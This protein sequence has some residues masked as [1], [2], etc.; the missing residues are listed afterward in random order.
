MNPGFDR[1]PR[2]FLDIDRT[3]LAGVAVL[4]VAWIATLA[5]SAPLE[6]LAAALVPAGLWAALLVWLA[7]REGLPAARIAL[8]FLWGAVIAV[9]AASALDQGAPGMLSPWTSATDE[10]RVLLVGPIVEELAKAVVIPLLLV[11]HP[12]GAGGLVAAGALYGALSGLGFATS[13]NVS[14]FL[15]ATLHGG[16]SGLAVAVWSRGVV[17][18]CKHSVY[19]ATTGLGIGWALSCREQRARGI[20]AAAT[21][22]V[23]AVLQHSAWNGLVAP[24]MHDALCRS[25]GATIGC[26]PT[27][28]AFD[29]LVLA[30]A[31]A[32]L[33]LAP[34][35]VGLVV[36][37]RRAQG[38]LRSA[39][40]DSA[41]GPRQ[42]DASRV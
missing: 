14:Y 11:A 38:R 26:K 33:A 4:A 5:D 2:R 29:L 12:R 1:S 34:A 7:R 23:A 15:M 21:A 25:D 42:D 36:L 17:A 13:E 30:P 37:R 27:S 40:R 32:V 19:A 39:Y 6:I 31:W 10:W 9:P 20:A 3:A 8:A 22:F 24:R 16:W 41:T 18:A 35:I 28:D